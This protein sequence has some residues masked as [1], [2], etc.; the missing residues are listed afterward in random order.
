MVKGSSKEDEME[1]G[2]LGGEAKRQEEGGGSKTGEA[3]KRAEEAGR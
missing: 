3:L 1:E 2:G